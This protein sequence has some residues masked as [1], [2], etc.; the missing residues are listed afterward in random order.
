MTMGPWE[1]SVKGW[2]N[3]CIAESGPVKKI[4]T[5]TLLTINSTVL[6]TQMRLKSQTYIF[7]LHGER[8]SEA[9]LE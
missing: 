7:C 4:T 8:V 9:D 2:L 6:K 5:I 1:V 3:D